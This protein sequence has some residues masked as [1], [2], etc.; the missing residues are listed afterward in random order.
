[1]IYHRFYTDKETRSDAT[2]NALLGSFSARM[3]YRTDHIG[4]GVPRCA[5]A[6][7]VPCAP[8]G[9][10]SDRSGHTGVVSL[11]CVLTCVGS[12]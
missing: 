9:R 10:T 11:H 4:R 12:G 8:S 5:C 6:C 2:V 7:A 1:M 3:I